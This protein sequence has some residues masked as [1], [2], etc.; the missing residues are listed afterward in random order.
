MQKKMTTSGSS[1]RKIKPKGR[2]LFTGRVSRFL[3]HA[4]LSSILPAFVFIQCGKNEMEDISDGNEYAGNVLTKIAV[5]GDNMRNLH[6]FVFSNDGLGRLDSYKYIDFAESP[7]DDGHV[8]ISSRRGEK[9]VAAVANFDDFQT[10]SS[11]CSYSFLKNVRG[12]LLVEDT[13][14]PVLSGETVIEAGTSQLNE[15]VLEPLCAKISLTS[16]EADFSGRPYEEERLEDVSVYLTGVNSLYGILDYSISVPSGLL[17]HGG[18]SETDLQE[19]KCPELIFS[20][21]GSCDSFPDAGIDLFCYPNGRFDETIGSS[22]TKLVIE[23]KIA[24]ETYYYPIEAGDADTGEII[25]N[26]NYAYDIVIT[27]TG[28]SSPDIPVMAGTVVIKASIEPWMSKEV[29]EEPF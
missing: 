6:I 4:L 22:S 3:T 23:G 20:N 16:L 24:G 14:Y 25:R 13:S 21:I 29:V 18:L 9:I 28:S 10:V 8:E 27:R 12:D 5:S 2:D 19:M 15:L 11:V 7:P 17:N 1:E 26:C